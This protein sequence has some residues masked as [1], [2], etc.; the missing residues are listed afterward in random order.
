MLDSGSGPDG[1][2]LVQDFDVFGLSNEETETI[3][4]VSTTGRALARLASV[5][6][7]L[8]RKRHSK[9][10]IFPTTASGTKCRLLGR[11][12]LKTHWVLFYPGWS[13]KRISDPES[14]TY[15]YEEDPTCVIS[16]S[17]LLLAFAVL[18]H[19]TQ[20]IRQF[21]LISFCGTWV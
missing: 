11:W 16:E 5:D 9:K 8:C 17:C 15:V 4:I 14:Y 7:V 21:M 2:L 1:K 18:D 19:M 10:M 12:V 6:I 20:S 3:P 13:L